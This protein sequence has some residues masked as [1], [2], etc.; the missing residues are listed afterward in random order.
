MSNTEPPSSPPPGRSPALLSV[1]VPCCDEEAVLPETHRRLV[2]VLD[3]V[4]DLDFELLYVDDGSRDGTLTLLRELQRADARVRVVALSRNFGQQVAITAGVRHAAGDVVGIIDADLQD[5]PELIPEMLDAWR[6]GAKVA[7]GV[8]SRRDGETR[9]KRWTAYAYYRLF[10]RL[11]DVRMPTDAGDFRLLDRA[12]VDAFLAM[13]E[14]DRLA[15]AMVAWTGFDHEAVSFRRAARTGGESKWRLGKMLAFAVDGIVSFS[16]APLRLPTWLGLLSAGLAAAGVVHAVT[17]R[18]STGAWVSGETA[19]LIAVLFTGGLQLLFLGVLG[20]YVGRIYGE[21]KRRP[22]YVIKERLGFA[23][24]DRPAVGD[25]A[26]E[27]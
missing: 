12:V 8:R 11:S 10:N 14:R 21:V 19:L 17:V 1:V 16:A 15:R 27:E 25:E 24:D 9:F 2:A 6:R 26:A 4:P 18:V 7:Y 22:L 3:R 23:S 20:E 5:P 13:P